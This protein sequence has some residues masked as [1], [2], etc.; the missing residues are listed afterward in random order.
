MRKRLIVLSVMIATIASLG[1]WWSLPWTS[2]IE[3]RVGRI[4]IPALVAAFDSWQIDR[5]QKPKR[6]EV[7][8][9][10]TAL[11][12]LRP[13]SARLDRDGLYLVLRRGFVEEDGV[14]ISYPYDSVTRTKSADPSWILLGPRVYRYHVSG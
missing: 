13:S 9:L 7:T 12:A 5:A 4:G 1:A 10:P 6:I 14:F 11:R 8:A 3:S 2:Q